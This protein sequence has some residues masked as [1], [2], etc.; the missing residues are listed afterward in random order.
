MAEEEA[1]GFV[2]AHGAG[3]QEAAQR[4]IVQA[5]EHA[6]NAIARMEG[7]RRREWKCV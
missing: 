6:R 7:R 3:A 5:L 2:E 4:G 1:M